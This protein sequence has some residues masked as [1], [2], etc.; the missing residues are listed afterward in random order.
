[1]EIVHVIVAF[2]A[3]CF[4]QRYYCWRNGWIDSWCFTGTGTVDSTMGAIVCTTLFARVLAGIIQVLVYLVLLSPICGDNNEL[5]TKARSQSVNVSCGRKFTMAA[6]YRTRPPLAHVTWK[7]FANALG[8]RA[9]VCRDHRRDW[10]ISNRVPAWFQIWRDLAGGTPASLDSYQID[11]IFSN[12][13]HFNISNDQILLFCRMCDVC[14]CTIY[15]WSTQG[16]LVLY[17]TS[18]RN[19][20]G[21]RDKLL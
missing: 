19:K 4:R 18:I 21:K 10:K 7:R 8:R 17:S 12:H 13:I 9:F 5:L 20:T 1:L 15:M 2:R 11:S 6:N 16:T 14:R 3:A